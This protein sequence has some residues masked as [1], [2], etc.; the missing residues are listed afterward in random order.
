MIEV[1]G[2]GNDIYELMLANAQ[3]N[4][5]Q[6]VRTSASYGNTSCVVN[7]KGLTSTFLSQ[8][9]TEGF[10]HV[11]LEENKTKIFWEW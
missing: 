7:S 2:L 6:S 5:V 8:L 3:N 1:R 10:D 11:E 9:E 4:I